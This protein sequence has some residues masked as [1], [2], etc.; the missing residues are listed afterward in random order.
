MGPGVVSRRLL[1]AALAA[2]AAEPARHEPRWR[3]CALGVC[4]EGSP[5]PI[6]AEEMEALARHSA[7]SISQTPFSWMRDPNA[8]ELTFGKRGWWGE[9]PEGI[10]ETTRLARERGLATLL[11]PHVWLHGSWPGDVEMRSEADWESWFAS[12]RRFLLHWAAFARDEKLEGLCVGTELD[13][14]IG[15]EK[16]W[17]SLIAEVRAIFPGLLTYAANWS[18]FESVPFWDSLDAIGVNAYF[19]LSEKS[20]PTADELVD[21]WSP[22]AARLRALSERVSRPIVFTEIGYHSACGAFSKPWEWSMRGAKPHA[23]DQASGYEAVARVFHGEPWFGGVFWWKW[24]AKRKNVPAK[25][26]DTDFTP[27]GKPASA[28]LAKQFRAASAP[29]RR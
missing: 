18:H 5:K 15:R 26:G 6:G 28:L 9:S 13:K 10:R 25:D 8:P 4:W 2:L 19:P 27:Q 14:T 16:E 24:H 1:A 12:Y 3:G 29:A 11:K 22:I 23:Q 17:R 7:N 21:A 20:C